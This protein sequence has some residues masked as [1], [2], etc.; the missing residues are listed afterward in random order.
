MNRPGEFDLVFEPRDADAHAID[1]AVVARVTDQIRISLVAADRAFA[2]NNIDRRPIYLYYTA[3]PESG[4]IIFS[5]MAVA[6]GLGVAANLSQVTGLDLRVLFDA[7]RIAVGRRRRPVPLVPQELRV[8]LDD[9]SFNNEVGLLIE[10]AREAN[11]T[12]VTIVFRDAAPIDLLPPAYDRPSEPLP[13][14]VREKASRNAMTRQRAMEGALRK[15][16]D[17]RAAKAR[18]TTSARKKKK[19]RRKKS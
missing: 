18:A 6:A 3:S 15:L 13:P 11:C 14:K 19:R 8:V 16:R 1:A 2:P 5:M 7:L 12:S 17:D 4:S 10:A 9:A